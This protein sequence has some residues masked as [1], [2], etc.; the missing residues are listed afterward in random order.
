MA[1][2][3]Y[4]E[5]LEIPAGER[6]PD[7]YT[8]LGIPRFCDDVELIEQA[9][10]RRIQILDRYKIHPKRKKREACSALMN[11]VAKAR[12]TLVDAGRR[13]VYDAG[14]SLR[15]GRPNE[16]GRSHA[17]PFLAVEELA[18]AEASAEV[19]PMPWPES[20]TARL[21]R[22]P[23]SP[24]GSESDEANL[25]PDETDT[26]WGYLRPVRTETVPPRRISWSFWDSVFSF[27]PSLGACAVV[28]LLV[29][30][31]TGFVWLLRYFWDLSERLS[32]HF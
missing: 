18:A 25:R 1:R 19:I 17:K 8:L 14:L 28:V 11:E 7:Y 5:W 27:L 3:L 20:D 30:G 12:V 10:R 6:P 2:D 21:D 26:A 29:L 22:V 15:L 16:E 13:R 23:P 4:T 32:S 31:A 24:V 9:A